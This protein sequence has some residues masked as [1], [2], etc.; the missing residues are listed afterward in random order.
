MYWSA[1]GVCLSVCLSQLV[2]F[3]HASCEPSVWF[4]GAFGKVA[5]CDC[6][7]STRPSVRTPTGHIFMKFRI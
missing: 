5:E 7:M 4:L 2:V 3:C 1:A 6:F